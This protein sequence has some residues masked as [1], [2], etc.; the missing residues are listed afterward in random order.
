MIEGMWHVA[1]VVA[2]P[3]NSSGRAKISAR[4]ERRIDSLCVNAS[5]PSVPNGTRYHDIVDDLISE[6]KKGLPE[7]PWQPPK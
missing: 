6:F 1:S 3:P 5:L 7:G 2:M 4:I